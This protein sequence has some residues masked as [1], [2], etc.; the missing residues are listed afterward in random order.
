MDP[1]KPQTQIKMMTTKEVRGDPL[2]DLP[3]WLEEFKENLVDGRVPEH[4]DTPS[5]SRELPSEPRG[6]VVSGKHCI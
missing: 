2:R 1:Q 4:R 6:K 5:S 3:E